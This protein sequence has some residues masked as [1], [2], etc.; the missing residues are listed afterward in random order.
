LCVG[1]M[2]KHHETVFIQHDQG[3]LQGL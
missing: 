2:I 1:L 3:E